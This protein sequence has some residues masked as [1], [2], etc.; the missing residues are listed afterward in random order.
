MTT[1][2][3]F[4]AGRLAGILECSTAV[5]TGQSPLRAT[6]ALTTQAK[7]EAAFKVWAQGRIQQILKAQQTEVSKPPRRDRV[8]KAAVVVPMVYEQINRH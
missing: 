2:E 6:R 4:Q 8:I 3:I 5:Q 1:E 7:G